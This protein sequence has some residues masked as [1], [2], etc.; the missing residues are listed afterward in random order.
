MLAP[1]SPL[2][3]LPSDAAVPFVAAEALTPFFFGAIA[4]TIRWRCGART[5]CLL[6]QPV[7]AALSNKLYM[8]Q[9]AWIDQ[10]RPKQHRACEQWTCAEAA[11]R[12]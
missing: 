2:A 8:E 11:D 1:A 5:Q 4:A 7:A 3:P 10:V 6:R 9:R 12:W